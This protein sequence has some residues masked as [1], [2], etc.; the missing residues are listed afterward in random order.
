MRVNLPHLL[1]PLVLLRPFGQHMAILHGG[2]NLL[3]F[4]CLYQEP[5]WLVRRDTYSATQQKLNQFALQW[6][7]KAE[8]ALFALLICCLR[9]TSNFT[10]NTDHA[11][12]PENLV[13]SKSCFPIL[14]YKYVTSCQG[15]PAGLNTSLYLRT[16]T[17]VHKVSVCSSMVLNSRQ[18]VFCFQRAGDLAVVPCTVL[19]I[20]HCCASS[21][22]GARHFFN[23]FSYRYCFWFKNELDFFM[24]N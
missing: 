5:I 11:N 18:Q 4:L 10:G 16:A 15:E 24:Q 20:T 12:L 7:G 21:E 17:S 14:I 1:V 9:S 22:L 23:V 6:L 13:L 8:V 19:H 3:G 2:I